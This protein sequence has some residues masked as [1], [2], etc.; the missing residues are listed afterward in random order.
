MLKIRLYIFAQEL[1]IDLSGLTGNKVHALAVAVRE[2]SKG[3]NASIG[4]ILNRSGIGRN[5]MHAL[6]ASDWKSIALNRRDLHSAGQCNEP[7]CLAALRS[8]ISYEKWLLTLSVST[9]ILVGW[10]VK[11][12]APL[13]ASG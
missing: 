2:M 3:G 9:S 6:G 8:S 11:G 10:V 1:E 4:G 13:S 7:R 12:V 5:I